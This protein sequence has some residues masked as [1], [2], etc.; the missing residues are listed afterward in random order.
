[1]NHTPTYDELPQPM[2]SALE[3]LGMEEISL[4]KLAGERQETMLETTEWLLS[5]YGSETDYSYVD[6]A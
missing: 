1:M 3:Q 6:A 4:T 5:R 2:R